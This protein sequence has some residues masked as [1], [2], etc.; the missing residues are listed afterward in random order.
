MKILNCILDRRRLQYSAIRNAVCEQFAML[1]KT[2]EL[3]HCVCVSI[4]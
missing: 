3:V 1:V 2:S 4:E